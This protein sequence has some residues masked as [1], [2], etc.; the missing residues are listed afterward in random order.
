MNISFQ[1][2][3]SFRYQNVMITLYIYILLPLLQLVKNQ[4][5]LVRKN[6][7]KMVENNNIMKKR[8]DK[9][10]GEKID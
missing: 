1:C 9:K 8:S 4:A 2:Q 3:N 10:G 6:N 5:F 7:L